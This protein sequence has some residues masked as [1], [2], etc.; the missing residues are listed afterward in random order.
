MTDSDPPPAD[1]VSFERLLNEYEAEVN[2]SFTFVTNIDPAQV[3]AGRRL[4]S[5]PRE[6]APQLALMT[7]RRMAAAGFHFSPAMTALLSGLVRKKLPWTTEQIEELIAPMAANA[8]PAY[9]WD[10]PIT[11]L[12]RVIEE[13][14]TATPDARDALRPGL[15]ALGRRLQGADSYAEFR[16]AA[17]R[18]EAMLAGPV[19]EGETAEFPWRTREPWVD[20]LRRHVEQKPA[21]WQPLLA[22]LANA[23]SSKPAKKWLADANK[24]VA[25]VGVPEFRQALAATLAQVGEPAPIAAVHGGGMP[26]ADPTLVH[27]VHS[28]LL[29]GLVWC[30]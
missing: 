12:L 15:T 7:L 11:G 4:L 6:A 29:R 10:I 23:G 17:Q 18:V 1:P 22:H 13:H 9:T 5:T 28:D 21:A 26:A 16:K 3:E 30:A 2:R 14:L 8:R 19:P 25:A 24:L 20:T 27:D